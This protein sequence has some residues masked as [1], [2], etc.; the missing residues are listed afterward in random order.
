MTAL[1]NPSIVW[2][3]RE[4]STTTVGTDGWPVPNCTSPISVSL[5][6]PSTVVSHKCAAT[7]ATER[8]DADADETPTMAANRAPTSN[9]ISRAGQRAGLEFRRNIYYLPPV[10]S[11]TALPGPGRLKRLIRVAG[12]RTTSRS[13]SR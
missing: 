3:V 1:P 10:R 4:G 11:I 9:S 6:F 7:G 5:Y 12:R 13:W 2:N 8:P